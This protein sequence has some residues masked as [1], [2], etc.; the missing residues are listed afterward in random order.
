M[1]WTP[2]IIKEAA[3]ELRQNLTLSENLLRKE[4]RAER[5]WIKF[6][7]QKPI[8]VF[9]ED[10]WLDRYIIADFYSPKSKLIIELDWTI[11]DI[12]EVYALDRIKESLLLKRWFKIIRFQNEEIINNANV[13]LQKIKLSAAPCSLT[14]E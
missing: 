8:F 2:N 12:K 7:R 5:I 14:K 6:Y 4:L 3:R 13:V 9:K 1:N 10:S 11:H